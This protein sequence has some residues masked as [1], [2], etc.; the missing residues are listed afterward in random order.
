MTSTDHRPVVRVT[1]EESPALDRALADLAEVETLVAFLALLRDPAAARP[2]RETHLDAF[3]RAKLDDAARAEVAERTEDAPGEHPDAARADILDALSGVLWRAE[4]LAW[5][6][7]RAAGV[8]PLPDALRDGDPRPYLARARE[9]LVPAV[10]AWVNGKEIAH[11]AADTAATLLADLERRLALDVDGHTV[12][13]VCPW[14]RGGLAGGYSWRVRVLPGDR[15]DLGRVVIVCESGVCQPSKRE[16]GSWW[17]GCP[18]WPFPQWAWLAKRIARLDARRAA[19]EPPARV[20]PAVQGATGRAGSVG[21][22]EAEAALLDGVPLTT[23]P[24]EP[25]PG[26]R[27]TA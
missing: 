9:T 7:S 19:L 14:C 12:K 13:A 18:I 27:M 8:E 25:G 4:D 10:K 24:Y 22:A 17:K 20:F 15:M 2:W 1:R 23:D 11:Y 5:H 6:L 26:G 3:A 16:A 21:T